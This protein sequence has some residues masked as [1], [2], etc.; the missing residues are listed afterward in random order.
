MPLKSGVLFPKIRGYWY[1]LCPVGAAFSEFA[2]IAQMVEQA[3]RKRQV[4]SSILLVGSLKWQWFDWFNGKHPNQGCFPCNGLT[5]S[6]ENKETSV[7]NHL[8]V[9]QFVRSFAP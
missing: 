3:F 9:V 6:K 7:D 1:N 2:N 5:C 8:W 4:R